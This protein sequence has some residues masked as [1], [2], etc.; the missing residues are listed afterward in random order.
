MYPVSMKETF[1]CRK[2]CTVVPSNI[3]FCVQLPN[4]GLFSV[5]KYL[6][7]NSE[8]TFTMTLDHY[9]CGSMLHQV[10]A[11]GRIWVII[12]GLTWTVSFFINYLICKRHLDLPGNQATEYYRVYLLISSLNLTG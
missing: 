12:N 9:M 6:G 1:T 11:G 2:S 10:W 4:S 7:R 3:H 8:Q 5:A